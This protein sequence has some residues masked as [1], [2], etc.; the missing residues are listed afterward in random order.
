MGFEPTVSTSER[1]QTYP[2]DLATTGTDCIIC[3]LLKIITLNDEY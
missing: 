3:G 1:P 2:L